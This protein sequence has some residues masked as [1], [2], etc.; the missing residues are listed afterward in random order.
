MAHEVKHKP[1]HVE[2]KAAVHRPVEKKPGTNINLILAI[3]G[4]VFVVIAIVVA[5]LLMG[6]GG[7]KPP[8]TGPADNGTGTSVKDC[9]TAYGSDAGDAG[10]ACFSEAAASCTP[11]KVK[12]SSAATVISAGFLMS[13]EITG[14][15]TQACKLYVKMDDMYAP[16]GMN[17]SATQTFNIL[18]G[19]F[20]GK[21]MNCVI[22]ADQIAGSVEGPNMCDVCTGP[23]MDAMREAGQCDGGTKPPSDDGGPVEVTGTLGVYMQAGK[24][25]TRTTGAI[26]EPTKVTF[27]N[28][29]HTCD[30][31]Q[32]TGPDGTFSSGTLALGKTWQYDITTKGDYTVH[33]LSKSIADITITYQ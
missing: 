7:Q 29:D 15:T 9:G 10:F 25:Y 16:T 21:A 26:T 5:L 6:Q 14:G 2:H 17:A 4:V 8:E 13:Q 11:A 32:I 12:L 19:M 33:C 18:A 28:Y 22:P 3:V 30:N 23:L 24:F 27:D 20:K 31:V 1:K